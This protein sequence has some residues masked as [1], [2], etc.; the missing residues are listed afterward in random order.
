MDRRDKIA[1][2]VTIALV[3]G[4]GGCVLAADDHGEVGAYYYLNLPPSPTANPVPN[5]NTEAE[6]A[7]HFHK[8]FASCDHAG[9]T[10]SL[11]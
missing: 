7:T 3:A 2:A 4:I 11:R 5:V 9:S 1:I 6:E 8:S 10:S